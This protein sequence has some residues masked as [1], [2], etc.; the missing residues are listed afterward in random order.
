MTPDEHRRKAEK[1]RREH[2]DNA[3]AQA[4]ATKHDQIATFMEVVKVRRSEFWSLLFFAVAMFVM[5]AFVRWV[6][7]I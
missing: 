6:W 7:S 2:P 4:S 3:K 5:Y 1:L